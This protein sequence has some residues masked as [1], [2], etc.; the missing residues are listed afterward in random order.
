MAGQI[1]SVIR[2]IDGDELTY[3]TVCAAGRIAFDNICWYRP[4]PL[5]GKQ[6]ERTTQEVVSALRV[7]A[8]EQA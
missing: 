8:H 7:G 6:V 1:E 4:R 5:V 3:D 2:F